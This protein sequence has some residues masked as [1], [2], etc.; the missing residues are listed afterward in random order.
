MTRRICPRQGSSGADPAASGESPVALRSR[1]GA[2]LAILGD[3]VVPISCR[4]R[5][6]PVRARATMMANSGRGWFAEH[7][8]LTRPDADPA[9]RPPP[10]GGPPRLSALGPA[11]QPVR[12]RAATPRGAAWS[13]VG[14]RTAIGACSEVPRRRLPVSRDDPHRLVRRA[15]TQPGARNDDGRARRRLRFHDRDDSA[16]PT[17]SAYDRGRSPALAADHRTSLP[18]RDPPH[19]LTDEA[20]RSSSGG[21][22]AAR[23]R[24]RCSG[25]G[26][27][28]VRPTELG[29]FRQCHSG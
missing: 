9:T 5:S 22:D 3:F 24:W 18:P 8:W 17:S 16:A 26:R 13:P 29:E 27:D 15:P 2:Q 14:A 25:I 1:T 20:R 6:P 4:R 11:V 28:A 7:G 10:A 23:G 21:R 19:A 12:P